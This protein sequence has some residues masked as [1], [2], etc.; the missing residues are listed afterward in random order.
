[1]FS[2]CGILFVLFILCMSTSVVHD[3]SLQDKI[4][5]LC[6]DDNKRCLKNQNFDSQ[7]VHACHKNY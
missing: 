7:T 3:I 1:M 4:F 5:E 6:H 2:I